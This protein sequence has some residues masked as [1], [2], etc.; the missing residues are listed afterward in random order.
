MEVN[1]HGK[2]CLDELRMVDG[3]RYKSSR[4][5]DR[6]VFVSNHGEDNND[7]QLRVTRELL[8]STTSYLTMTF[9]V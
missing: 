1:V 7:R 9:M 6:S 8:M 5:H 4:H 3:E 2:T